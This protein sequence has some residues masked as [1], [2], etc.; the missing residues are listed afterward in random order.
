MER[1]HIED[2]ENLASRVTHDFKEITLTL[3][4]PGPYGFGQRSNDG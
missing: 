1:I 4:R 2:S 3:G